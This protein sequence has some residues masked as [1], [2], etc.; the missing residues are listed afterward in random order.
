M[1]KT[2]LQHPIEKAYEVNLKAPAA[3]G[4]LE[5][6]WNDTRALVRANWQV[7]LLALL[8]YVIYFQFKYIVSI[9]SRLSSLEK[10]MKLV[11]DTCGKKGGK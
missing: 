4:S 1:K 2:E 5:T 7:L 6:F 9:D 10:S 11:A 3:A 8:V